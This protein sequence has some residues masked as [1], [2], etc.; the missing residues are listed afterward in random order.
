MIE[1]VTN[2]KETDGIVVWNDAPEDIEPMDAKVAWAMP[3]YG[4]VPSVV[5]QNHVAAAAYAS[6]YLTIHDMG[7]IPLVGTT[8]K[9]YLHSA[10]NTLVREFLETDC[11]HLFWTEMDMMLP[12]W[13]IPVLLRHDKPICSGVYFLRQGDGQPCLYMRTDE[14]N[15]RTG[16]Y[17][18]LPVSV[19]PED[20]L[21]KVH[22][23]GFGCVM[24]QREVFEKIDPPWFD[25]KEGWDDEKKMKTGYG[26]D[27]FFYS[28]ASDANLDVWV[29]SSIHCAQ[30]DFKFTSIHEYRKRISAP[31]YK[32][33]GF[34]I[35]EGTPGATK[36]AE[37]PI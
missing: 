28:K 21:F 36:D 2:V 18:L 12:F 6:R 15:V 10:S 24:F 22:C 5:Y 25:L 14:A 9:M 29:D 7:K 27:T 34:I 17:G 35:G 8:D 3:I 1:E 16:I 13:A 20:A 30:V 19:F 37:V 11:T 31:D 23:P 4:P 26:Q 33:E 32:A